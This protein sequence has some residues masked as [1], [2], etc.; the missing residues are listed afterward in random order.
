MTADESQELK[1]FLE[2]QL[3]DI[4]RR[5][6]TVDQRFDAVDQR[7][8]SVD[9]RFDTV[10]QRF[11]AVDQRFLEAREYTDAKFAEARRHLDVTAEQLRDDVQK[12]AEGHESL[13]QNMARVERRIDRLQDELVAIVET[14]FKELDDRV[15]RIEDRLP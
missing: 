12:I 9:Q 1:A 7:F 6:D 10:D 8:D 13:R 15:R 4:H 2:R 5:F 11:D 14:S 3:A